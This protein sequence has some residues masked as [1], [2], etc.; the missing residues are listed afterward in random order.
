MTRS[1]RDTG[2]VFLLADVNA[3]WRGCANSLGKLLPNLTVCQC[4]DLL[5]RLGPSRHSQDMSHSRHRGM[6]PG[7][8]P[9][10]AAALGSTGEGA[11]AQES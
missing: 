8:L 6:C 10:G 9:G 5:P 11:A 3:G 2:I 4:P 1:R 7:M